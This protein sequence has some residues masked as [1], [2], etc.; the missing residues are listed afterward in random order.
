M[1]ITIPEETGVEGSEGVEGGDSGIEGE[2][3]GVDEAMRERIESEQ[4]K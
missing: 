2:E 4:E 1:E 3:E